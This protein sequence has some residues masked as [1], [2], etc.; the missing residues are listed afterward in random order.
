MSKFKFYFN[1]ETISA[2]KGDSV[3]AALLNSKKAVLGERINGN[4]RGLYCGM[5]VCNECLVT[6]NG[7]RGLR[8]C[9]QS[10]KP[11]AFVES[12]ID[13]KKLPTNKSIGNNKR[14]KEKSDVIIVGAGPAGLSAAITANLSGANV[15]VVDEREETGGQYYKPRTSGYRGNTKEDLQHREGKELRLTASKSGVRFFTGQTVWY[16]RKDNGVFE[17]RC[18]SSDIQLRIFAPTLILC[19]G[20]FEV[21][22]VVPGWTLP[23]VTTIGAA[24]TMARRYGVLPPGKVLIAGNGPLGLQLTNE[25]LSLG[26]SEITLIERASLRLNKALFKTAFYSP[27]LFMKGLGYQISAIKSRVPIMTGWEIEKILGSRKVEAAIIKNLKLNKKVEIEVETIAT[28]EGFAPQSELSRLLGV[29]TRVDPMSK[30][31]VPLRNDDCSTEIPNLWIAGDAGGMGGAELAVAQGEIA[32]IHALQTLFDINNRKKLKSV[33]RKIKRRKNFQSALWSVYD[34][35]EKGLPEDDYLVCRCEQVSSSQL[36]EAVNFGA[37]DLGSIKRKTRI[38]MGRCQGRYCIPQ[39]IKYLEKRS[40]K[41]DKNGLFA[42]QIPARPVTARSIW[43]EKPEWKG[44][45]ETCLPNR[46]HNLSKKPLSETK[47]DLVVIGGGV[48]GISA[49]YFAAKAGASVIC[50]EQGHIN[51]EAS[52]GNAGSLHVQL[53]SWD[54]GEK[55]VGDGQLQLRTLPLQMESIGMWSSL[56]RQLNTDFEIEF[57]G[58]LMVAE[59]NEQMKFLEEK[60]TAEQKVGVKTSLID[61]KQIAGIVPE[62]SDSVIAG[63]WCEQEGKINPL[64]ATPILAKEALSQGAVIEE[65]TQVLGVS[66]EAYGY[67]IITNRGKISAKKLIV[68]AGGWSSKIFEMLNV[69]IPIKG[70]PLQ[71]IVTSPAPQIVNCLMYHAGRHLTLKQAK[72]GSIIIGGAWPA[73]VSA[74]GRSEV[75]PE[76]IEGNL[77]AAGQTIPGIGD[78]PILRTWGAMNIDIDGAPLIGEIPGY[79]GLTVAATAN[80]YTLGPLMGRE[81]ANAA[82]KGYLRSDLKMFSVDRFN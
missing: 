75:L 80:G 72:A 15:I 35:P 6:I 37:H 43:L 27:Q 51:S 29:S 33:K 61:Q 64:I 59:N 39:A 45:R 69:A 82:L 76:S 32:A 78:V 55:A 47:A 58:G 60:I 68:A 13:N 70:A 74:E 3:A 50:I 54:F 73:N 65:L 53:L 63:S 8:A 57:T 40:L 22:T 23:G 28:G 1:G 81:V 4:Q 25:L 11:N 44:H 12:E 16:A 7:E 36:K 41:I 24:Q 19:T 34:A 9:M 49:S 17:L 14:L 26:K 52:G 21:P 56:Q 5:G 46:P 67:E 31:L 79:N 18:S 66:K 10:A 38:G 2:V 48:T 62:I 77:W 30:Q 71:M 20:A 42:P